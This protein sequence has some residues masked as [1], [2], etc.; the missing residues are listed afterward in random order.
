V[1]CSALAIC[2][3]ISRTTCARHVVMLPNRVGAD[4]RGIDAHLRP[5]RAARGLRKTAA[6]SRRYGHH[7]EF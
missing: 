5:G 2:N 1:G 6:G 7:V 3:A 4:W